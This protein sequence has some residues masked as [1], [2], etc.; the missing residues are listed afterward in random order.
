M[1]YELYLLALAGVG[2]HHLKDWVDLNKKGLV[3]GWK[4]ELPTILLSIITVLILVYLKDDISNLYVITPFGAI[5][6][7]YAG[8]S[9]FFSFVQAKQ[10]KIPGPGTIPEEP[11]NNDANG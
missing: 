2:V 8:N 6:L 3:Y 5:V 7:G 4:K 9:I 1:S 11:V 10:P